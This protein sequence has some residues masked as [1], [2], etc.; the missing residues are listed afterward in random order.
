MDYSIPSIDPTELLLKNMSNGTLLISLV[1]ALVIFYN[2]FRED[3]YLGIL[4]IASD[5]TVIDFGHKIISIFLY[6]IILSMIIFII[7]SLSDKDDGISFLQI[8]FRVERNSSASD[9]VYRFAAAIHIMVICA[10]LYMIFSIS[11][12]SDAVV[13]KNNFILIFTSFIISMSFYMFFNSFIQYIFFGDSDNKSYIKVE[14]EKIDENSRNNIEI[15]SGQVN[16]SNIPIIDYSFIDLASQTEIISEEIYDFVRD[17]ITKNNINFENNLGTVKLNNLKNSIK[18]LILPSVE[19]ELNNS[20]AFEKCIKIYNKINNIL[21]NLNQIQSITT[22]E[23]DN[24]EYKMN[25]T[26]KLKLENYKENILKYQKIDGFYINNDTNTK[27]ILKSLFD[28]VLIVVINRNTFSY[29]IV[30]KLF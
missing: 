2:I 11:F 16:E 23:H 28:Y 26:N 30:A 14:Q 9:N 4:N 24:K 29:F 21:N 19:L 10:V 12:N 13:N 27:I 8:L 17:Q 1:I 25:Q 15:R 5:K 18:N 3:N 7:I 22:F 20:S 6:P